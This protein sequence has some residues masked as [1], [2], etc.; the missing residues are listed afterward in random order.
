MPEKSDVILKN[1]N[2]IIPAVYRIE[3]TVIFN[4]KKR[5]QSFLSKP[6]IMEAILNKREHTIRSLVVGARSMEKPY[7]ECPEARPYGFQI[8]CALVKLQ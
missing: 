6:R 4:C 2:A 8:E 3:M 5:A 7:K 1:Y